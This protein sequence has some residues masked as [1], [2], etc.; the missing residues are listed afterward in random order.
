MAKISKESF[1]P[2]PHS[3]VGYRF[4]VAYEYEFGGQRYT[5]DRFKPVDGPTSHV[6]R[7]K[8]R[9][10]QFPSGKAVVCYVDPGDPSEALLKRGSKAPL[11][12]IWFPA[13]FV[14]GGLGIMGGATRRMVGGAKG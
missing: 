9:L 5:S 13:L 7:A 1:L 3:P 14:L 12:S 11:Y 10:A 2:T 6:D 8:A 4:H